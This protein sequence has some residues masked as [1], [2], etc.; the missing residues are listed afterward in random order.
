[1]SF[2]RLL[3]PVL[4]LA[5]CAGPDRPPE[6]P[7]D[8]SLA[9]LDRLLA[10]DREGGDLQGCLARIDRTG[11]CSDPG[12]PAR[13]IDLRVALDVRYRQRWASDDDPP[14]SRSGGSYTTG[15]RRLDQ[16]VDCV[17]TLYRSTGLRFQV[18][19]VSSWD[20]EGARHNLHALLRRAQTDLPPDGRSLVVGIT[21]WEERRVYSTAGGE[22]GLSQRGACVV[23]SWPRIENDCLILAHELG[24]LVGAKHVPGRQ[25]IMGWAAR[26]FHLPAA[27]PI[28][29]LT[30]T[31]G[32]HPRNVQAIRA[33]RRARYAPTG[34]LALSAACRERV[35]Q[36]DRCWRL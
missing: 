7:R 35:R 28:A 33:H 3:S 24:H 31:Y 8:P 9:T 17:N 5:A 14:R 25:W 30:A 13:A 32:F 18:A 26:P 15:R 29:R 6:P 20:P 19:E 2:I 1:M 16:T 11:L 10:K 22:I 21:L 36:I 12:G 27:D 4:A 23:P 34:G